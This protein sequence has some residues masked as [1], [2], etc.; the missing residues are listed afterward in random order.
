MQ[1]TSGANTVIV[2]Q[3]GH[4]G[5]DEC[6]ASIG[7]RVSQRLKSEAVELGLECWQVY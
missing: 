1:N 5:R 6:G 4:A 2:K 7:N 3:Q